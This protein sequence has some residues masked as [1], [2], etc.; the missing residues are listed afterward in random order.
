MQYHILVV[1]D[2]IELNL[3]I[4]RLLKKEG[5]I[6]DS[7]STASEAIA[8]NQQND[9]HLILLD[10]HLP[11][12]NGKDMVNL[13]RQKKAVP[14]IAL[15]GQN[16]HMDLVIGLE[17]GMDDY[18]GKPFNPRELVARI[19]AV[20][21]RT[22]PQKNREDHREDIYVFNGFKLFPERRRLYFEEKEISLTTT[23]FEY[24]WLFVR[25]PHRVFPREEILE[26]NHHDSLNIIDRSVD[27]TIMRLR[28]K[29][30]NCASLPHLIKTIRGIG[31]VF[32]ADVEVINK[33][34]QA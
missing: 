15:T 9:I 27:V 5:F 14:I 6:I 24:L 26:K 17:I 20:L 3:F 33:K 7:A 21:R 18:I 23:E 11:D 29:I 16:S 25:A 19:R 1:D 2:D 22:Y 30:E 34:G 31:Y 32:N 12:G 4:S 10:I 28:R 13:F 8:L